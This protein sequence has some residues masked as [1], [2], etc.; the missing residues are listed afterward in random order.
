MDLVGFYEFMMQNSRVSEE[1]SMKKSCD[2]SMF[3]RLVI[4]NL[5]LC[6]P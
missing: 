5:L 1:R 4:S 2:K 3:E 6:S